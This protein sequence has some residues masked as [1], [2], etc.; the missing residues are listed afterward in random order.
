MIAAMILATGLAGA[1]GADLPMLPEAAELASEATG[2]LLE[3]RPLPRDYR[4]RL[5]QMPPEARLQALIFLRRSGLLTAEPWR[6]SDIL[7]P[8]P[9]VPDSPRG[10]E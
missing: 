1:A 6:L 7:G 8:A 4:V 10:D 5:M 9:A 3:G 2:W